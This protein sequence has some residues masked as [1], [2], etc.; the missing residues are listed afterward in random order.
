MHKRTRRP[1]RENR[2]SHEKCFNAGLN[3]RAEP[4]GLVKAVRRGG[5]GVKA[6][7]TRDKVF[8]R[9]A[10]L[11]SSR[12]EFR[13]RRRGG[14]APGATWRRGTTGGGLFRGRIYRGNRGARPAIKQQFVSGGGRYGRRHGDPDIDERWR[15]QA[16][17]PDRVNWDVRRGKLTGL[18][19]D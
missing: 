3:T 7:Y 1:R 5:Q 8:T 6:A 15:I 13:E 9:G 18:V 17:A 4:P 19:E 2:S 10:G 12:G 16:D 11:L 14:F